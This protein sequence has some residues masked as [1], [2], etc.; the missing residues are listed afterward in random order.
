VPVDCTT[1]RDTL[2]ESQLFGHVKGAFTG[3]DRAT[4]GFFRAAEGG[5]L[6]LDEIGELPMPMQAKLLRVIQDRAVTPLGSSESIPVDVRIIA[7]TNR[8]M[9]QQVKAGAFREDLYFRLNVVQ[10]H[11]PPLRQRPEEIIPLAQLFLEQQA[12]FYEE[13]PKRLSVEA[14]DLLLA[15]AWPGNVRELLNAIEHAVALCGEREIG[16]SDLPETIQRPTPRESR[17]NLTLHEG[18]IPT[19][20]E[21]EKSLVARAL[22]AT[23]GNKSQAARLLRIERRRLYRMVKRFRLEE[24]ARSIR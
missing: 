4:G 19:L 20:E 1:L 18:S 3:A 22:R 10:I 2:F 16:P 24:V 12:E 9:A 14:A 6:F 5:T 15:Y 11:V 13:T 23:E 17:P 21:A 8:D 7:A